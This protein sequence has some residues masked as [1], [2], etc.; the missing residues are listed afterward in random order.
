MFLGTKRE[1]PLTRCPIGQSAP[2]QSL[3]AAPAWGS[4]RS[5]KLDTLTLRC[6]SGNCQAPLNTGRRD[7]QTGPQSQTRGKD[8]STNDIYGASPGQALLSELCLCNA[9]NPQQQRGGPHTLASLR[10]ATQAL[11][12]GLEA[13]LPLPRSS[14]QRSPGQL[15]GLVTT[16]SRPPA[17]AAEQS[18]NTTRDRPSLERK[19]KRGAPGT[20]G[21]RGHGAKMGR[22]ESRG[23]GGQQQADAAGTGDACRLR[24]VGVTD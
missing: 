14:P 1:V 8:F 22:E 11:A 20:P 9:F 19:G 17:V 21:G 24:T 13:S 5:S 3:A 23:R 4:D 10:Q 6:L 12:A 2:R 15:E 7:L 16:P 18:E